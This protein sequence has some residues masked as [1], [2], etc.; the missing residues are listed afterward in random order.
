MAALVTGYG[1]SR[2]LLFNFDDAKY[3]LWEIK[4]LGYL[5]LHK[6]YYVILAKEEPKEGDV[7][8]NIDAFVQ[9]I[10]CLDDLSLS[11]VASYEGRQRRRYMTG[12]KTRAL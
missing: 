7:E 11:L 5:A 3:E 2:R 4:F 1:P 6:L 10:Q 12:R 9:L 8:K